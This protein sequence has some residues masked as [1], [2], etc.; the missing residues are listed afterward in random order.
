MPLSIVVV[1]VGDG[2]W[3]HMEDIRESL[4]DS[5]HCNFQVP[6]WRTEYS[7]LYSE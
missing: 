7:V 2:P 1:G 5:H 3:E 4:I 6:I